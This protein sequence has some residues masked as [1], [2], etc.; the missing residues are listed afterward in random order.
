MIFTIIT[1]FPEVFTPIFSSSI[2]GR[3]QRSD[4][5]V[6]KTL[7]LRNFGLGKHKTVDD[8]PYGGGVGMVLRVDV[9][10]QAIEA[11]RIKK[12]RGAG[13]SSAREI[14][15]LLDPKGK[16]YKQEIVE[17]FK[18]YDH[19]ILVCGHYE[20]FDERIRKLV[21]IEI[22]IGDYVLSGGEIAAMV[23][24]ESVARLTSGVLSKKDA[25]ELESF[26][27][28]ENGRILEA[29]VYTRPAVY[30]N[31][32]VPKAL[33]SGDPKLVLEYRSTEAKK[34]TTKRRPDLI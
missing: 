20:G 23:I 27:K 13:S 22:S 1:L 18:K 3:A 4:K 21:D 17:K 11:A 30:N 6:I 25:H 15:I 5:I 32:R 31:K 16:V 24:V 2:L 14:V 12:S 9:V 29:P 34:I 7:N 8:K 10:D 28:N 26:S 19:L 33:F